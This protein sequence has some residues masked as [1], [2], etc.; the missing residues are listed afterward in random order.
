MNTKS[1]GGLTYL[2][3]LV[4]VLA[5]IFLAQ[6][7]GGGRYNISHSLSLFFL[8]PLSPSERIILFE[9]RLPRIILSFLVGGSLSLGGGVLQ[10]I[11]Q[12][13]LVDPYVLGISSGASL[14]AV[15]AILSGVYLG[16]F[17]VPLFAFGGAL[18]S[19][20]L[21]FYLG[22]IG[23][24]FPLEILLL[25][26]VGVGFFFS[27]LVSLGMFLA[28]EDLHQL[29]FWTMGGFWNSSWQK[30]KMI[31]P[32]LLIGVPILLSFFRELNAFLLGE[33]VAESMGVEVEKVKK[34]LLFLVSLLIASA[35]A[36]SGVIGF[37]GL[38][39]PHLV[40]LLGTRDHRYLLPFSFLLGG[41]VLLWAD[42]LA[43]TILSPVELPVGI[44]TNLLGAPFFI[45]L[46]RA[47][48]KNL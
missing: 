38:V 2:R 27:A 35:V 40:R 1:R 33:K 17:T 31:L 26:G 46:L 48:K 42:T 28:G 45:Y 23:K 29:V 3:L 32:F 22:K 10:G 37:V 14:G 6:G 20:F 7:W 41:G 34:W 39:V 25:A 16:Y 18:L 4:L 19:A 13:P 44:I 11:F 43:R 24:R 47:R 12:N 8:S 21:V 15:F 5:S 36:V 30:V 9:I